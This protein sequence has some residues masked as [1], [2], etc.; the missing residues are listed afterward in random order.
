[1]NEKFQKLIEKKKK[2]GKTLSPVESAAKGSVLNEL[3]D[4]AGHAMS[5][6][7]NGLKKVSVASDSPEGLK[8]GLEKAHEIVSGGMQNDMVDDA[9]GGEQDNEDML[10]AHGE[11]AGEELGDSELEDSGKSEHNPMDESSMKKDHED[12]TPEELDQEIKKLHELRK[13]KHAVHKPY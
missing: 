3:K 6:K 1:M 7:L 8:H 13:S 11:S 9:E 2:E 5:E 10:G 12:M 4:M